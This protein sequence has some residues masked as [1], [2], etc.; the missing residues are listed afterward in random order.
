M[1]QRMEFTETGMVVA[2]LGPPAGAPTAVM[3]LPVSREGVQTM[4]R[5]LAVL[6]SLHSDQRLVEWR[7]LCPRPLAHGE[8]EGQPYLVESAFSGVP[9]HRVIHSP[10]L[11]VG[12]QVAA[13]SVI[14][15]LHRRTA[16]VVL[17]DAALL[18]LWVDRPLHVLEGLPAIQLRGRDRREAIRRLA[19]ELRGS[20][21]GRRLA[22][23][24]V[25]GDFWP[26][27]LLLVP[28]STQPAGIV[29]W[30]MAAP[31]ELPSHD[32]LHLLLYTRK[33]VRTQELGDVVRAALAGEEWAPHE[34]AILESATCGLSGDQVSERALLL[35]YWLRH[36]AANLAQGPAYSRNWLWLVRNIEVVLRWL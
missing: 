32:L 19:D 16:S 5:Q 30:D 26:G 13:A 2:F 27:N 18:D 20:L 12:M 24:W 11:R 23:S 35:I 8:F 6:E 1:I 17:V 22:V 31:N 33:L 15:E 4:Y 29:D 3:K 36:V 28:G 7:R 9:A 14:G 34:Q 25:H 21:G 10:A